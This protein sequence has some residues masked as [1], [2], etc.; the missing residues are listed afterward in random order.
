MHLE[1]YRRQTDL[2]KYAESLN[3]WMISSGFAQEA[4]ESYHSKVINVYTCEISLN[5]DYFRK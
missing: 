4:E 3:A 1:L 2:D 5:I